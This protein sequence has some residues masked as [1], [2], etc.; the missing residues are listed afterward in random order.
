MDVHQLEFGRGFSYME[1]LTINMLNLGNALMKQIVSM[2]TM[3]K[4]SVYTK[5]QFSAP[6]KLI[7]CILTED[8]SKLFSFNLCR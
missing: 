1:P 5:K 4:D 6:A 8:F 7:L 2:K 3:F